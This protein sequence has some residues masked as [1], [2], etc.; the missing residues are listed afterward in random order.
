MYSLGHEACVNGHPIMRPLIMEFPDDEKVAN[1]T[2]QWLL[3]SG[4]MAA[5]V[6]NASGVRK[7]ICLMIN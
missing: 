6:M 7:Y 4:L 5:P 1:M 2:D 3:G